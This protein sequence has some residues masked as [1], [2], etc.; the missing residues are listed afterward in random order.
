MYSVL[1]KDGRKH[2][3]NVDDWAAMQL[4][5]VRPAEFDQFCSDYINEITPFYQALLES[6]YLIRNEITETIP[7]SGIK[8]VVGQ[9]YTWVGGEEQHHPKHWEWEAK[10]AADPAVI[11]YNPPILVVE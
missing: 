4:K 6:G 9:M 1:L 7:E 11:V 2:L 8:I 10:M 3:V 5:G